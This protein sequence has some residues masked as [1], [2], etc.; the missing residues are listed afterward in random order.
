MASSEGPS[1]DGKRNAAVRN[2]IKSLAK[3]PSALKY[4]TNALRENREVVL[5]AAT[6]NPAVLEFAAESL[7]RDSAF[8]V[9]CVAANGRALWHFPKKVQQVPEVIVAAIAK[10][11]AN[12]AE[13]RLE[14]VMGYYTE[15]LMASRKAVADIRREE[16]AAREEQALVAEKHQRILEQEVDGL[17][18]E[19]EELKALNAQLLEK[20][21]V[22]SSSEDEEAPVSK[23]TRIDEVSSWEKGWEKD[24]LD[25]VEDKDDASFLATNALH[26]QCL[27][28]SAL[29][30]KIEELAALAIAAGADKDEVNKVKTRPLT[31]STKQTEF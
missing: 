27:N 4:A 20:C 24:I 28:A 9:S 23:K 22:V 17:V 11:G 25:A 14:P 5:A 7:R 29:Q 26:L 6:E 31:C 19:V 13:P 12:V 15:V 2:I 8:A 1:S 18:L 16:K 21:S 30:A 3:N 10:H